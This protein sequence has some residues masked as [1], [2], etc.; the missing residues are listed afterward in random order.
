[1]NNQDQ[2]KTEV[3]GAVA[4]SDLL[5]ILQPADSKRVADA[6]IAKIE[7][8]DFD[9]AIATETAVMRSLRDGLTCGLGDAIVSVIERQ[10]GRAVE[11][12]IGSKEM[13]DIVANAIREGIESRQDA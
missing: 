7:D 6:L 4:S 12:C 8:A 9:V 1:M 3:G 13:G 11:S 10:V 5:G 2:T